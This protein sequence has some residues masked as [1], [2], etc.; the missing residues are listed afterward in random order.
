M[1]KIFNLFV[2]ASLVF[3]YSCDDNADFPTDD[4][5]TGTAAEG[6][7]IVAIHNDTGGKLLGVPSSQDFETATVSFAETELNLEIILM[8]GG[9][10]ITGYEILKSLNGGEETS[11]A[12]SNSLPITLSYTSGD[13]FVSGL[14]V[15]IDFFTICFI[16]FSLGVSVNVLVPWSPFSP[17]F[18]L[19]HSTREAI[20]SA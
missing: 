6:G 14:G 9:S 8:S 3:A 17:Y 18:H 13:E 11:V 10:D 19:S 1:K 12:T 7:A 15:G 16:I 4:F 2:A 20:I 5:L